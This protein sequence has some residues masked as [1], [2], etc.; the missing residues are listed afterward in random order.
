M[1]NGQWLG[2]AAR[3]P[4]PNGC[5]QRTWPDPN[6]LSQ[7]A[8]NVPVSLPN[9]KDLHTGFSLGEVK[10][11]GALPPGHLLAVGTGNSDQ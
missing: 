6:R 8:C 3:A 9:V 4:W 7:F 2:A 10:A 1:K 5:T 11:S